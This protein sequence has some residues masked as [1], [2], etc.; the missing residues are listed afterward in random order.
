MK[1]CIDLTDIK[2][3]TGKFCNGAATFLRCTAYMPSLTVFQF[4]NVMYTSKHFVTSLKFGG[5][6]VGLAN[7]QMTLLQAG[8]GL[9]IWNQVQVLCQAAST[10][11]LA[12]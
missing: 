8:L 9:S 1:L 7:W 11:N 2:I 6:L 12:S 3:W 4:S 5:A 10:S